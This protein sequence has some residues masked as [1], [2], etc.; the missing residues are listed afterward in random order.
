[1]KVLQRKALPLA[2][3]MKVT[4]SMLDED[5]V[6]VRAR[7]A[8]RGRST[9]TNSAGRTPSSRKSSVTSRDDP[10]MGQ[11]SAGKT[12]TCDHIRRWSYRGQFFS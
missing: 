1:M 12:C 6:E 7:N 2:L 5:E 3:G 8:S 4:E 9:S 11:F 10:E